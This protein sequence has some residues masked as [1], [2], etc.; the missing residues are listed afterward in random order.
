VA[1]CHNPF[2]YAWNDRDRTLAAWPDPVSRTVLRGMFRRWRQ[3]DWIAAQRVNRYVVNSSTTQARVRAYF[4]RPS[5]VVHPPV[6]TARF[7]PGV[8]GD[9]YVVVSELMAH[10]RIDV[11]VEAFNRLRLPLLVVGD[12]PDAR[13]LRR[14]AGPTVTFTGRLPDTTVAEVLASARALVQTSVEEFGIAAVES[15]AAGR[16]VIARRG[17]GVLETVIDGETGCLWSGGVNEL[18]DA[19]AHF[20]DAAI[21]SE[22]CVRNASRFDA[23]VFRRAMYAEV[24]EACTAQAHESPNERRALPPA[25]AV[26]PS[27]HIARP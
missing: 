2:R 8:L 15:Q 12:G 9:H 6:H 24:T 3:W 5:S 4:G 19:V 14:L 23:A 21:D 10:K 11:A 13:R 18:S 26:T 16:P 27:R 17:G 22:A 20:D 1:Y 25:R 7:R